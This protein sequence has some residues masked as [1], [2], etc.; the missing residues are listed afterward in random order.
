KSRENIP[1][2]NKS[3]NEQILETVKRRPCTIED[4]T[5]LLNINR[6]E[7]NKYLNNLLADGAIKAEK[8]KRGIFFTY[9][10]NHL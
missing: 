9:V 3:I 5:A 1:S 8:Q 4:L 10:S 2:F 7:V 6:K